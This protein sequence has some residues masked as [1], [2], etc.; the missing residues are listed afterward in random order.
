MKECHEQI[1]LAVMGAVKSCSKKRDGAVAAIA[2]AHRSV[3]GGVVA[4][5]GKGKGGGSK[6]SITSYAISDTFLPFRIALVSLI[7][8][9][10][11]AAFLFSRGSVPFLSLA[12]LLYWRRWTGSVFMSIKSSTSFLTILQLSRRCDS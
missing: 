11:V 10:G 1:G 9:L 6:L 4:A 3:D 5:M 8:F 7:L 12:P 2:A